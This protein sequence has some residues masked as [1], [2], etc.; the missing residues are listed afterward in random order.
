MI[1][2]RAIN[3]LSWLLTASTFLLGVALL[4]LSWGPIDLPT[5]AEEI[6]TRLNAELGDW[7]LGVEGASVEFDAPSGR[8]AVVLRDV[9]L[10]DGGGAEVV[11]APAA[12]VAFDLEEALDGR[13]RIEKIDLRGVVALATRSESGEITFALRQTQGAPAPEAP[14]GSSAP[15]TPPTAERP[16]AAALAEALV[17]DA[18]SDGSGRLFAILSGGDAPAAL[19]GLSELSVRESSVVLAD[20]VAGRV[21]TLENGALALRVDEDGYRLEIAGDLSITEGG[22]PIPMA[23]DATLAT[24]ATRADVRVSTSGVAL[25]TFVAQYPELAPLSPIG[26]DIVAHGEFQLDV[27]TRDISPIHGALRLENGALRIDDAAAAPIDRVEMALFVDPVGESLQLRDVVIDAPGLDLAGQAAIDVVRDRAGAAEFVSVRF[28]A[29][30]GRLDAPGVFPE[31]LAIERAAADFSFS[32]CKVCPEGDCPPCDERATMRGIDLTVDG[33]DLRV[34]GGVVFGN[35]IAES[36]FALEGTVGPIRMADALRLWPESATPDGRAWMEENIKDALFTRAEFSYSGGAG[37]EEALSLVFA[38]EDTTATYL[39]DMPPITDGS[40]SGAVTL[41]R[42]ELAVESGLVTPPG[43]SPIDLAGSRFAIPSLGEPELDGEVGLRAEGSIGALLA[44]LDLPPLALISSYGR[45][46]SG[47]EGAFEAEASLGF[48]LIRDF[49]IEDMSIEAR[50]ALESVALRSDDLDGPFTSERLELVATA[51]GARITGRGAYQGLRVGLDLRESF[52]AEGGE[53]GGRISVALGPR[54]L[55]EAGLGG[56]VESG[57]VAASF[58]VSLDNPDAPID[59]RL[60][61]TEAALVV[62]TVGWRKPEGEAATAR[63]ALR[64]LSGGGWRVENISGAFGD[65]SFAGRVAVGPDGALRELRLEPIT[66]GDDTDFAIWTEQREGDALTFVAHGRSIDLS[67]FFIAA[68]TPEAGPSQRFDFDFAFDRVRL[69]DRTRLQGFAAAGQRF[70]DGRVAAEAQAAAGRA[71]I[72]ASLE[73]EDD[74]G[75]AFVIRADRAGD[76]L[77][78]LDLFHGAAGGQISLSGVERDGVIRGRILA[79]DIVLTEAPLLA[80]LLSFA[81][82]FGLFDRIGSG[83]TSF[84]RV[85]IPFRRTAERI[86]IRDAVAT[87]PSLGISFSGRIDRRAE[88]IDIDGTLSPANIINM[89]VSEVPIIGPLLAGEGGIVGISF[90]VRGALDQPRV[91]TNPLSALTP[92]PFREILSGDN[93][94]VER[95]RRPRGLRRRLD[96]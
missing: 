24:G 87:G 12:L 84:T 71:M 20:A 54:E 31:V 70:E 91:S 63:A 95:A 16:A 89:V 18:A 52:A 30:S 42:F 13:A 11:A 44:L 14:P 46:L 58:G 10:M 74:G 39:A 64:R 43:R 48:P 77:K 53:S 56:L 92:G 38:F 94:D 34:S 75:Q 55:A 80:E 29:D 81:T 50:A 82:G 51:E 4:R 8:V 67:D 35:T 15:E 85:S 76:A 90:A 6:E 41:E 57:T 86:D 65:L 72:E 2:R 40:G 62:P 3:F 96:R 37:V 79:R 32:V 1:P 45:D 59:L 61:A 25:E 68:E 49:P 69:G 22:A 78:A 26:G 66:K 33:V 93:F 7:R 17:A 60:D 36:R 88:T 23:L 83:G 9:A 47:F 5:V 73:L 21:W 27:S 28:N 19:A